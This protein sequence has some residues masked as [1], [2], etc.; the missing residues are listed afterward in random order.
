MK[1]ISSVIC[2]VNTREW[3]RPSLPAALLDHL[4][5]VDGVGNLVGESHVALSPELLPGAS[6]SIDLKAPQ[7]IE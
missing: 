2:V 1:V 6:V 5:T 4:G 7:G 3:R